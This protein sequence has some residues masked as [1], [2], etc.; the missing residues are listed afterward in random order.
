MLSKIKILSCDLPELVVLSCGG[1]ILPEVVDHLLF[2]LMNINYDILL[3]SQTV[4]CLLF[5]AGKYAIS[6]AAN[7]TCICISTNS[8]G[9]A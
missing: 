9:G 1:R 8:V 5:T 6:D 2:C 4:F 3:F 7:L